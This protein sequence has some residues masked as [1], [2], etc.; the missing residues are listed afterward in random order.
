MVC[1]YGWVFVRIWKGACGG[2]CLGIACI[3]LPLNIYAY[4]CIF[5]MRL[6]HNAAFVMTPAA[7]AAATAAVRDDDAP[8]LE[9]FRNRP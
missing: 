1:T 9:S 5:S 6:T 3:Q 4:M 8:P 2:Y 7:A